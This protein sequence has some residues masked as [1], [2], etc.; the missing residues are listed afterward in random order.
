[1]ATDSTQKPIAIYGA[2]VSN[3]AIAVFKFIVA[4]ITGSSAM[5]SEGIHSTADTG[6]QLLLLFGLHQSRKPADYQ[7]PFGHGQELYFWSLI[8]AIILFSAGGGMSIYE[9]II[10]LAHPNELRN[11]IWNYIV[12]AIALIVEGI[13]WFIATRELLKYKEPGESFWQTLRA[14]KDPSIFIVV[15]EDS[16]ALIGLLVAFFGVFLGQRLHSPYPDGIASIVIGVILGI[17]A[18]FLAYE[19][20]SLLVGE[21]AEQSTVEGIRKIV[22]AHPALEELRRPLTLHFGPQEIL[23]NLDVQ[24]RGDQQTPELVKVIDELEARIHNEYPEIQKIFIEVEG[25]KEYEKVPKPI[26]LR[27]MQMQRGA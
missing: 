1:M 23:L 18:A 8:V 27:P 7:H 15:G 24:F 26:K 11:T 16:A 2:I 22:L 19:S 21:T 12:L 20:K 9:G 4:F 5:L 6:N 14:S 17:I 25:L 10:H 3:L 13:S